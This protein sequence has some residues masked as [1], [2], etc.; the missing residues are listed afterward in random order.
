MSDE[1]K[2]TQKDAIRLI[3][4]Q[5]GVNKGEYVWQEAASITSYNENVVQFIENQL[6]G[7]SEGGKKAART[8]RLEREGRNKRIRAAAEKLRKEGEHPRNIPSILEDQFPLGSKQ[9]GRIIKNTP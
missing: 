8:K 1:E 6:R 3:K 9:I 2:F 5:A 4:K 7:Q